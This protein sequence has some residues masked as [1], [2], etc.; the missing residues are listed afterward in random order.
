MVFQ[1]WG[2]RDRTEA[3]ERL[4]ALLADAGF[5]AERPVVLG[6][7]RGGVPVAAGVAAALDAP[8][9]VIV[10]RKLGLPAQPEVALG[11][12]GEGGVMVLNQHLIGQTATGRA[13]L[14][15]LEVR[16]RALLEERADRYRALRP[17]IPLEGRCAVLVDDGLATGATARAA[18]A[19]ARALGAARV[20]V[21]VPVAAPDSAEAVA[22]VADTLVCPL[23]PPSFTAVGAWYTDFGETPDAEVDVLLA[24][25]AAREAPEA[26]DDVLVGWEEL[27]GH[28]TV[29]PGARS[30]V[31]FAHGSG[32]GACSPRNAR[33]ART[34]ND[35]GLGTL[36]FDLLRES[37][38]DR[39]FDIGFLAERLE[40]A[41]RWLLGKSPDL[42]IGYF[43][44][45]TGAAAA[46]HAA[47]SRVSTARA[48]VSRGGRPDLAGESLPAVR[49][50]TLLIVGGADAEVLELNRAAQRRLA[51]DNRLDVVPGATH[52]FAEPG[53]LEAVCVLAAAWFRE[54]LP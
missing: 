16:E 54:H 14:A 18:C 1:D 5:A 52:L 32:S 2:Y 21:A 20:V 17:R 47:A 8:L 43:G 3:G 25:A 36:L 13:E 7:P 23:R 19:V 39:T 38:A 34:L 37:E 48:V 24:L 28:L 6:L 31:L 10:V 4:G 29:P 27:P 50:P 22:A 42:A 51:C 46:L 11:A 49:A 15:A 33:V 41:T 45:S 30:V 9:D 35:A 26:D 12:V 40:G 53:A 44:A